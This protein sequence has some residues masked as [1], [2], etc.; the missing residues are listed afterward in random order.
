[1]IALDFTDSYPRFFLKQSTTLWRCTGGQGGFGA[2]G[3]TLRDRAHQA[4][5]GLCK[6]PRLQDGSSGQK[7]SYPGR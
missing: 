6:D 5:G 1:M 4:S 2:G 7:L 3:G